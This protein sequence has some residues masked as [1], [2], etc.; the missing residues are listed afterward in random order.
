MNQTSQAN[1]YDAL[2]KKIQRK[3]I[4]V[5]I[6]TIIAIVITTTIC[7]PIQIEILDETIIDY[8]GINPVITV[9]LV[10]LIFFIE[11]IAYAL[12]SSPLTTSMDVECDPEK[13]L[14]LN[15]ALNKQKNKNHIYAVALIYMG[16]FEEALDYANKMIACNKTGMILAGLFNKARCEFFLGDFDSLKVTVKQYESTLNDFKEANQKT[17]DV[18]NKILKTM[19]LLIAISEEDK[20][21]ISDYSSIEVWKNSKATEGYVNYLKGIVAYMT[22]NKEEAI[23]RFMYVKDNCPKTVLSAKSQQYLLKLS[24]DI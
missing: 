11:L 10:V 7:S 17:K 24:T 5:I 12:V 8:K 22:E 3:R 15:K 9:L 1:E 19:N 14:I 2:I 16:H 20:D 6:L 13:Y 23:Y 18:Y 21:G 4:A